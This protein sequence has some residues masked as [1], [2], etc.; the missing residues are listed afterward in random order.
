MR[1]SLKLVVVFELFEG[2]VVFELVF[3]FELMIIFKLFELAF[4]FPD[5]LGRH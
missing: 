3:I 2:M 4:N 1:C 5:R